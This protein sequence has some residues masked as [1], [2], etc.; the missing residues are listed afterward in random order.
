LQVLAARLGVVTG[1][2]LAE[3]CRAH[4]RRHV[5]A[6]LWVVT[7]LAIIGAD[8][9]EIIGSAYAWEVR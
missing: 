6:G 7:E 9:Q 3:H 1:L 4:Y 8:V 5:A 2:G